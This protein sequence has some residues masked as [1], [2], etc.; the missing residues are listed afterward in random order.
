MRK[1]LFSTAALVAAGGMLASGPAVAQVKIS[2][3]GTYDAIFTVI[4]Q[5]NTP[6]SQRNNVVD[7][8]GEIYFRGSTTLDNGLTVGVNVEL[9]AQTDGRD[10]IDETY[11]TIDGAFGRLLVGEDDG[12]MGAMGVYPAHAG[13][14]LAG[15]LFGTHT[16]VAGNG[17]CGRRRIRF[18]HRLRRREDRVV[19]A[20]NQRRPRRPFLYPG[21]RWERPTWT[22]QQ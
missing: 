20:E 19:F 11:L 18:R 4:D 2:V 13:V 10:Q 6:A 17:S 22:H 1:L 15:I 14:G 3:G 21:R 8:D 9:E 12:A 16:R 5:D 7:A